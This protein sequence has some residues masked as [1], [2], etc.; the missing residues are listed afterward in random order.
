[1]IAAGV[2]NDAEEA[3]T[4]HVGPRKSKTRGPERG[5]LDTRRFAVEPLPDQRCRTCRLGEPR[6]A[7]AEGINDVGARARRAD[8][9]Q[10]VREGG[11]IAH[12]LPATLG[13]EA[14]KKG[15]GL[16]QHRLGAGIVGLEFEPA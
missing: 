5:K 1:G 7:M 8:R 3:I 15:L 12:P 16:L 9:R 6:M 11:P 2:T 14:G 13:P 10:A 4:R